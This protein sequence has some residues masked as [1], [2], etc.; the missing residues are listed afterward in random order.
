M[1]ALIDMDGRAAARQGDIGAEEWCLTS[2]WTLK[3]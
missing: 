2:P 3:A 1:A